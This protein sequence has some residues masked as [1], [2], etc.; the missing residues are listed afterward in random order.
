MQIHN[1]RDWKTHIRTIR[2]WKAQGRIRFLGIT[3][4]HEAAYGDLMRVMENEDVDFV[5]PNYSIVSR[6]AEQR[7]L[8]L[9]Q[10]KRVAVLINKPLE[11]AALFHKVR[12]RPLPA[13][14]AE[15]D[16][17]SWAQFFLKFILSHPAV[18]GVIPATRNPSHLLDNMQAGIGRLPDATMRNRM[19]EAVRRL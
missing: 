12:G 10:E 11:T 18:T 3:H 17:A 4:Y 2:D 19:A 16:C 13:W 9:A 15:F 8:P 7:L 1:L 6:T 5:Q 14:A